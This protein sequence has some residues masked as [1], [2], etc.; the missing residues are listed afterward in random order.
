MYDLLIIGGGAAALA[1][2][3]Y[4]RTKD[5]NAAL[6]YDEFG[7]KVGW[8]P[9]GPD[10]DQYRADQLRWTKH[11]RPDL[12]AGDLLRMLVDRVRDQPRRLLQ[13]RALSVERGIGFLRVDTRAHGVLE[14]AT[15]I[16]AT[17]AAPRLL[18][19]AG[20]NH[21]VTHGLGYSIHAYTGT[22]AG[23][24]V[25]VIGTTTRA[26]HGAAELARIA[27]Y[28]YIVAPHPG[29]LASPI[30]DALRQ[31]RNVAILDG[32]EVKELIGMQ[33]LEA[34]LVAQDRHVRRLDVAH[35]FVDLGLVPNSQFV[36]PLKVTDS[37]GF[38]VVDEQGAT[39]VSGLFAAGD[40]TTVGG[41]HVLAA[42]GDGTRAARSA[43][44][45]VLARWLAGNSVAAR[46][47]GTTA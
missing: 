44:R 6:L 43:Y 7:G 23:K 31:Q 46:E 36:M 8:H 27:E 18:Q 45:Y 15:V 40:V 33:H 41:E 9:V 21:L 11:D 12:P 39:S 17:G 22:V 19:V 1:A 3:L 42:M 34:V 29:A 38:V 20:A 10:V 16:V 25:A 32:Y 26:V 24:P 28:V 14:A 5:L 35:A 37:N 2:L 4:A 47:R 30:G 13:D